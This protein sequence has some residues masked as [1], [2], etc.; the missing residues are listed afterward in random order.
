SMKKLFRF[1]LVALSLVAMVMA[2]GCSDKKTANLLNAVGDDAEAV[3]FFRPIDVLRSMGAKTDGGTL[4]APAAA[5]DFFPNADVMKIK[6]IDYNLA[7]IAAYDKA[8]YVVMMASIKDADALTSSLKKLDYEKSSVDGHNVYM[9][10]GNALLILDNQLIAFDCYDESDLDDCVERI[11]DRSH[12][13]LDGWKQDLLLARAGKTVYGVV[14][15]DKKIGMLNIDF[16]GAIAYDIALNGTKAELNVNLYD[17]NGK[18]LSIS[19]ILGEDL[20]PIADISKHLYTDAPLSVAF[21][22]VKNESLVQLIC[23]YTG[24]PTNMSEPFDEV[25]GVAY[26]IDMNNVNV[27]RL[28]KLKLDPESLQVTMVLSTDNGKGHRLLKDIV[29][30]AKTTGAKVKSKG[31]E[32]II[33]SDGVD[34]SV[35]EDGDVVVFALGDEYSGSHPSAGDCLAYLGVNIPADHPV[36]NQFVDLGIGFKGNL[37][38]MESSLHAELDLVDSDQPFL[39]KLHSILERNF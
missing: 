14:W 39:Q 4:T 10:D 17:E 7:A 15:V 16:E 29:D 38:V 21:G 8:P 19:E 36:L 20:A 26:N 11:I 9:K 28:R 37:K 13:P 22:G 27:N 30:L 12:E 31:D 35:K 1:G 18:D 33:T 32:Y 23:K 24:L 5:K 6:G 3:A 2:S 25:R 34:I